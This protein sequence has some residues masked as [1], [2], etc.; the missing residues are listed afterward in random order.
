MTCTEKDKYWMQHVFE[1]MR[2]DIHKELGIPE[3]TNLDRAKTLLEAIREA[4]IGTTIKNPL[5][6][7][8]REYHV[9]KLLKQ[10]AVV[11][12]TAIRIGDKHQKE[13]AKK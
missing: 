3:S 11:V 4:K 8:K 2:G 12:L 13:R 7:G 10:N 9:T 5:K 1:N 6:I